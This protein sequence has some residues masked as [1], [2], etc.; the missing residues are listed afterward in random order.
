MRKFEPRVEE[1]R[2]IKVL[3]YLKSQAEENSN[4]E[5]SS[6]NSEPYTKQERNIRYH[7]YGKFRTSQVTHF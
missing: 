6:G 7:H 2:N 5:S 3:N 4:Y 1:E